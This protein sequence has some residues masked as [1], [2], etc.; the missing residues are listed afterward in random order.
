[1]AS[2]LSPEDRE[3]LALPREPVRLHGLDVETAQVLEALAVHVQ[4]EPAV[5][6]REAIHHYAATC[7]RAPSLLALAAARRGMT[8]AALAREAGLS[9]SSVTEYAA[10]RVHPSK[11]AVRRLASALNLTTHQVV[12]L[13]P[14]GESK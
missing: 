12:G 13:L 4:D 5:V 1:M 8:Q 10:G 14:E 2:P 9:P 3:A 11:N 6:L 7:L